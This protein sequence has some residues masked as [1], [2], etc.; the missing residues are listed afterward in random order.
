MPKSGSV[1]VLLSRHHCRAMEWWLRER[2]LLFA[3]D[4]L[5][6]DRSAN[7]VVNAVIGA[8][9]ARSLDRLAR[10]TLKG[11]DRDRDAI[12]TFARADA[13]WLAALPGA[14]EIRQAPCILPMPIDEFPAI[15]ELSK[16]PERE[17]MNLLLGLGALEAMHRCYVSAYS[18]GR[19]RKR[20]LRTIAS[21]ERQSVGNPAGGGDERYERRL[22]K[23]ARDDER[24][25]ELAYE[26]A[27]GMFSLRTQ[28]KP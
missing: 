19:G 24:F 20:K 12:R 16:M 21:V 15:S 1:E 6:A 25:L 7:S 10:R 3:I 17:A 14:S 26:F 22:R 9:L 2:Y 4:Q 13:C 8:K 18:R 27:P 11:G 23:R 28:P 5:K